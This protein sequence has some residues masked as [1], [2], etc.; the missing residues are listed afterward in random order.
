MEILIMRKKNASIEQICAR[1]C[2]GYA[3]MSYPAGE[4]NSAEDRWDRVMKEITDDKK[5]LSKDE[6]NHKYSLYIY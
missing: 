4:D 1:M 6:F 5:T 2:K 3:F